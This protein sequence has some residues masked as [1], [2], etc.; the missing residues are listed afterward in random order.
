MSDNALILIA[1]C[2]GM[3]IVS[4]IA[5]LALMALFPSSECPVCGHSVGSHGDHCYLCECGMAKEDLL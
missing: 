5:T 4:A 1:V 3:V 2:V